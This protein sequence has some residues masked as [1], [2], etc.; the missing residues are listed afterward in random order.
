MD[1][2]VKDREI[3]DTLRVFDLVFVHNG[4]QFC[5]TNKNCQSNFWFIFLP[6]LFRVSEVT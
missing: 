5:K 4:A 2:K 6:V 3:P 1:L